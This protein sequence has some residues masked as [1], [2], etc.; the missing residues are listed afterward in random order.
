M[1]TGSERNFIVFLCYGAEGVF[2][3]CTYALLALSRLYSKAELRELEVWV[4]TDKPEWF[5]SFSDCPVQ[6]RCRVIDGELIKAWRGK[7]DFVH[8]IKVEALKDFAASRNGNVLYLDTDTVITHRMDE[9]WQGIKEGKLY[10]HVH[11]GVVS[12]RGNPILAKLDAHLRANA[13]V[14]IAGKAIYDL[15]MWNAGALG[16]NTQY[17]YLLDEVLAFTD[18]EYP[19]FPKHI[20]EQFA[21]SV[22]FRKVGKVHAL[23]PEIVHYW[24][25][26][27][28]RE[29]L[30]S[31]FAY[32][33]GRNWYDLVRY[34]AEVQMPML[35]QDKAN[36]YQNRN[37]ADK[38]AKKVWHP[39]VPEWGEM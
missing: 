35:M 21:F 38:L 28:A 18:G 31:F 20:V 2:Y 23:A 13:P 26:K 15:A 24:N 4:Y 10:M 7:I 1:N 39:N 33:K 12:G 22:M 17:K 3:E 9:V 16:F 8:R 34:A 30:A 6:V 19:K 32:F 29:V 5:A 27:E 36:Y 37:I 25:L 11:E 14:T